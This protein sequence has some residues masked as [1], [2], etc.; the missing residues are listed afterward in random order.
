MVF[1]DANKK[2]YMTFYEE[3]LRLLRKGGVICLDNVL[4][5]GLV[6]DVAAGDAAEGA[7]E[8]VPG[9]K[10]AVRDRKCAEALHAVNK[11]VQ[12]DDRVHSMI[13]PIGDGLLMATKL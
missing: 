5:R 2:G 12:A 9:D 8:G 6:A 7:A 4:W 11:R 13:L 3:G 10:Q 1:I